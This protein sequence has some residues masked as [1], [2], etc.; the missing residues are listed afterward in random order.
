G[1]VSGIRLPSVIDHNMVIQQG[2]K[3]PIWGWAEPGQLINVSGSWQSK[4]SSARA[5]NDG[6]WKVEID[7]PGKPG[8]P[9]EI[10]IND[11]KISN[12]LCGEVWVC[13]GQSNM[14]WSLNRAN[15]PEQE[16][17]EANYPN[18]RLFYVPRTV[19]V[20]PQDDCVADW[21]ECTPEK[22]AG[23]SAVAYFFGRKLHKKLNVPIGL[24]NTS[25]GGTRIEPWTPLIGFE[26]VPAL[27]DILVNID[28]AEQQYKDNVADSLDDIESWAQES[29]KALAS[30]TLLPATPALPVHPLNRHQQPMALYNSMIHPLLPFPVKG[31]IWY[32]GESNRADGL[33]YFE[34]MKALIAGWRS[35]W[36]NKEMPFYYVQLAP[37]Y[38]GGDTELLAQVWQ[39]QSKVLSIPNTGMAV[40]NDIGNTRD[41][42]PRNKQDVGKRLAL[43]A[44]AKDYGQKG[45]VYSGPL[46]DSL[47]VEGSKIRLNF[48]HVGGGLVSRDGEPLNWF[49]I[50]GADKAYYDAKAKIDGDN[51]L[52]WS[53]AV[54]KPV[55][56]RYAWHQQAEPNLMNKQGLP[57][58]SFR[59]DDWEI[60]KPA[61]KK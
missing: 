58:S 34:K 47:A 52:V 28:K 55:A 31:G 36:N 16:I 9:H 27:T 1:V 6:K 4:S 26:Q 8:G 60:I 54:D 46:Y 18:I 12:V 50:A 5:D 23:F 44:L 22:T 29:R 48:K 2:V 30:D 15:N 19:A 37:Y 43:W 10:S 49:Y 53:K 14:Q 32:Q 42:H 33:L 59:T 25:W 57:A 39:A 24:I 3:V 11:K 45:L 51:V 21:V 40:I 41:I 35:V 38:Y 13:S 17:A 20:R 7:P 56:V 61:V